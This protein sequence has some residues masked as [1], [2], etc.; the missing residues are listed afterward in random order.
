MIR[1]ITYT[2]V[3]VTCIIVL[4]HL[5]YLDAELARLHEALTSLAH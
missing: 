4:G 5:F 3:V 1:N 2:V